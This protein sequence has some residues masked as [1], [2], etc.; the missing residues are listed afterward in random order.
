MAAVAE[1]KEL[2]GFLDIDEGVTAASFPRVRALCLKRT[3]PVL[4]E[5]CSEGEGHFVVSLSL[6]SVVCVYIVRVGTFIVCT[7]LVQSFPVLF[8]FLILFSCC[9]PSEFHLFLSPLHVGHWSL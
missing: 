6:R 4:V 8:L 3:L 9:E 5:K 7:Y 1:L 2:S